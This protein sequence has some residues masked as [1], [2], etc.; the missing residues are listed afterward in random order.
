[1]KKY[2][3][4]LICLLATC[5]CV[6]CSALGNDKDAD[7]A[8]KD[9]LTIHSV[10]PFDNYKEFVVDVSLDDD[11]TQNNIIPLDSVDVRVSEWIF[12]REGLINDAAPKVQSVE[13]IKA[14]LIAEKE[15]Q[16]LVLLDLTVDETLLEQQRTIVNNLR[17][18][19]AYDNLYVAFMYNG[20][21]TQSIPVTDYVVENYIVSKP[22]PKCLFA[23][24]VNK[25][26]ELRDDVKWKNVEPK[27]KA[28][29]VLSDGKTY[30]NNVPLDKHHFANQRSLLN[31]SEE[32]ETSPI[33][34]IQL[35]PQQAVATT[36]QSGAAVSATTAQASNV[37]ANNSS[38]AAAIMNIIC[39]N[40]GGHYLEQ[41]LWN[42][43][44]AEMLHEDE[45][46]WPDI[47]V[48]L[49]NPDQKVYRGFKRVLKLEFYYQNQ[50]I[51]SG[52]RDYVIG[53]LY[54]PI[55][56]N[57]R[58]NSSILVRGFV[59]FLL[60]SLGIYLVF[61]YAVPYISYKLFR[62]KYVTQ[63]KGT[64][65]TFNQNLVGDTCYMCK[66]PFQV[67]DS[68]VAKCQHTVHESCWKENE[69]KCPEYGRHCKTGSHYYNKQQLSDTRN[70]PYYL[71]WLLAGCYAGIL[72]WLFYVL[73]FLEIGYNL[74]TSIIVNFFGLVP[75]SMQATEIMSLLG[76]KIYY[77]PYYGL[78][79]SFFLTLFLSILSSN[80]GWRLKRVVFV[81][82]KALVAAVVGYLSFLIVALVSVAF[83]IQGT[84]LFVDWIPW[85]INGFVVVFAVSYG[86]SIKLKR[87][88][89]GAA[90]AIVFSLLS[91]LMWN[92]MIASSF[93]ARD[94]LMYSNFIYCIG[95]ALSISVNSPKSE[96]YMLRVEG[97]IKTTYVALYKWINNAYST[98]RVSIGKSVDCNLQMSWDINSD[99][100]PVQAELISMYGNIYL[101]A[102]EDKGVLVKDKPLKVGVR[103]RLYHGDQ[104]IIGKTTFTYV[105]QDV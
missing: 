25:I 1:M 14:Q 30:Q 22:S 72:S 63:Y 28:L 83:S 2:V 56:V 20:Q 7:E 37:A 59:V 27:K 17:H 35:S 53:S 60:V 73:R 86:T 76:D 98:R 41:F 93:D 100:A 18:V 21:T 48:R 54:H 36:P 81:L 10:V 6:S 65:M 46:E 32:K 58:P 91:M 90:I 43:L 13:Y 66:T 45:M 62:R 9:L 47:R 40:T 99:I 23:S 38:E 70:A 82:C 74:I 19:Y 11:I 88:L 97:P 84:N 50:L 85:I 51:A 5:L 68:I 26:G 101:V 80:G 52:S 103:V 24:I 64:N 8:A 79:T 29:I 77:T 105:E 4:L 34:Y 31:L 71:N 96:R 78:Y 92:F 102:T 42:R 94:L 89:I 104:F 15:L 95:V 57:G 16:A 87:A 75:N 61:Q 3:T 49:E 67:G 39:S 33:Y 55:V 44:S 69:Y 12:N